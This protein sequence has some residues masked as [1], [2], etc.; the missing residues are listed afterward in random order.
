MFSFGFKYGPPADANL[1]LDV[2]FLPNPYWEDH[3]R[4]LTGLDNS[5]S[6]YVLHS[7]GGKRLI[8]HLVPFIQFLLAEYQQTGKEQLRIGIGCTGGQHR[9]VAVVA[10][11]NK[12][13]C[14]AGFQVTE[15]HR[16]I[17]KE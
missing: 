14:D 3:L 2:R 12:Q 15:E 11:L 6:D 16:D 4:H 7:E 5:V 10:C 9:S 13:L 17:G 8:Q 1:V